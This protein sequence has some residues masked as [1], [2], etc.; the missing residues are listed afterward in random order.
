[1]QERASHDHIHHVGIEMSDSH[2]TFSVLC[3]LST[4]TLVHVDRRV[5]PHGAVSNGVIHGQQSVVSI[6]QPLI[7]ELA[8]FP[9]ARFS[10]S[11]PTA[12]IASH[13]F[14]FPA[15]FSEQDIDAALK[16]Q[17]D[18]YFP[19]EEEDCVLW[20]R[21][22]QRT[23]QT[24]TVFACAASRAFVQSWI[25]V[26]REA[27]IVISFLD[28]EPMNILRSITTQ[29]SKYGAI[30]VLDIGRRM[31]YISAVDAQGIR[32]LKVLSCPVQKI[33]HEYDEKKLRDTLTS[34][35]YEASTM[36]NMLIDV[37]GIT[38]ENVVVCGFGGRDHR[39]VQMLEQQIERTLSPYMQ[40]TASVSPQMRQ[41]FRDG[42]PFEY[43]N[44]VGV[45][46]GNSMQPPFRPQL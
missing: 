40:V 15:D 1:M 31:T 35:A 19:Y 28:I 39:L 21:I 8:R 22:V 12:R 46:L 30:V 36:I 25:D 24:V 6:L 11:L 23:E 37:Y 43:A 3:N 4:P 18:E 27:G 10:L 32:E 38:V 44:S 9:N 29:A 45:A 7:Q 20:W 14:T 26:C 5:L 2:T 34:V 16:S 42:L 33:L 17:L 41:L 13:V